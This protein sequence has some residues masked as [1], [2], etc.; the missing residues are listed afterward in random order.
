MKRINNN[1]VKL[2]LKLKL[3]DAYRHLQF[4]RSKLFTAY[5][6]ILRF[7]P[8]HIADQFLNFQDEQE[9][10]RMHKQNFRINN[11]IRFLMK[12]CLTKKCQTLKLIRYKIWPEMDTSKK[13]TV[14][15]SPDK[16][17]NESSL[18]TLQRNWFVNLSDIEIYI[19]CTKTS[20]IRRLL[21]PSIIWT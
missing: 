2:L 12:K 9:R 16:F 7:F 11:K 3:S 10:V 14:N 6:N 4:I 8:N 5:N 20:P 17:S 18:N 13:I 21:W 19:Q 15:I 1:Y